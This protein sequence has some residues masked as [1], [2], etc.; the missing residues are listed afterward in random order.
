MSPLRTQVPGA[1]HECIIASCLL[2]LFFYRFSIRKLL[3]PED[4]PQMRTI[5]AVNSLLI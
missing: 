3:I 2:A 4:T 5:E 1:F